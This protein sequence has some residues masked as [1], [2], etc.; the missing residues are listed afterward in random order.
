MF[1]GFATATRPDDVVPSL[2]TAVALIVLARPSTRLGIGALTVY[3]PAALAP[4]LTYTRFP[5]GLGTVLADPLLERLA[6]ATVGI[7]ALLGPSALLLVAMWLVDGRR[8][9]WTKPSTERGA[10]VIIPHQSLRLYDPDRQG[11]SYHAVECTQTIVVYP[12]P[13]H[14]G[15]RQL[16]CFEPW[17][18]LSQSDFRE[19]RLPDCARSGG[20]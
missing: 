2:A 20:E 11:G 19:I 15:W 12:M 1:L 9:L 4:F 14:R 10:L 13:S 5:P 6:R 16:T 17:R 3:V 7:V 8:S 18:P